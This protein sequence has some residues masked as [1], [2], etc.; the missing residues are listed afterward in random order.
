[1]VHGDDWKIGVQKEVREKVIETLKTWGG[2]L[3]ELGTPGISSTN[4]IEA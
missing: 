4:L 3:V 1:M 2:K